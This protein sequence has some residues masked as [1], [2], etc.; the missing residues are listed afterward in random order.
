MS[1]R[2]ECL[3]ARSLASLPEFTKKTFLARACYEIRRRESEP[4][5]D[6]CVEK[7]KAS[8]SRWLPRAPSQGC[9][10]SAFTC[11]EG[12]EHHMYAETVCVD[13]TV[14]IYASCAKDAALRALELDP[15]EVTLKFYRHSDFSELGRNFD[16]D[17]AANGLFKRGEPTINRKSGSRGLS[18]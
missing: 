2:R 7:L 17:C 6:R 10:V 5:F 16:V 4:A 8:Q 12:R 18:V 1:L 11:F 14:M 15:D 13:D 3:R 9:G